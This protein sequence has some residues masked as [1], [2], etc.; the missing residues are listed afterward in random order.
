MNI[1]EKEITDEDRK[2]CI[3]CMGNY[4]YGII[5][6]SLCLYIV[7]SF[8]IDPHSF[9]PMQLTDV[10]EWDNSSLSC[11]SNYTSDTIALGLSSGQRHFCDSVREECL[12]STGDCFWGNTTKVKSTD[13]TNDYGIP[14]EWLSKIVNCDVVVIRNKFRLPQRGLIACDGLVI[15]SWKG[16]ANP[17]FGSPFDH[18]EL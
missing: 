2:D 17:Y 11:C 14:L 12:V 5:L 18:P 16:F 3:I 15:K 4:I 1:D 10:S 9:L 6:S 8:Y 7:F 13:P